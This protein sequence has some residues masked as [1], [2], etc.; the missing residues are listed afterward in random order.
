MCKPT[1]K[2]KKVEAQTPQLFPRKCEAC[3]DGM[4]SGYVIGGGE[5]YYC[6]DKCLYTKYSKKE[7]KALYNNGNSESYFTEWTEEDIDAE[8]E[9]IFEKNP[10]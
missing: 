2:D 3:G 10:L 9:P 5:E 6:S 1:I 4:F 7:W 8:D